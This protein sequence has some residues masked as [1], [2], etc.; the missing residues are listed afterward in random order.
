MDVNKRLVRA[1]DGERDEKQMVEKRGMKYL[2]IP[3]TIYRVTK[4]GLSG[5][6]AF[7]EMKQ[8][9]YGPD[10]LHPEFKKFVQSYQPKSP[11]PATAANQQ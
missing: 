1:T 8:Y 7:Q 10:F 4:D 3:M 5:D 2:N 11:A 6:Q 9:K